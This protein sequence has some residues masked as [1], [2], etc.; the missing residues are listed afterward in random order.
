[1][2]TNEREL[3]VLKNAIR[4]FHSYTPHSRKRKEVISN[5]LQTL[6]SMSSDPKYWNSKRVRTW[7]WNHRAQV[8]DKLEDTLTIVT[9]KR[10][11]VSTA[12]KR[13]L[14][15]KNSQEQIIADNYIIEKNN[16][17]YDKANINNI[18]SPNLIQEDNNNNGNLSN[19]IDSN[20]DNELSNDS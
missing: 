9:P 7:F 11:I 8:N 14:R 16:I 12:Y 17:L 5:T 1:M 6:R 10:K 3:N 19:I 18:P 2:A 15:G 20:S 13:K 4:L